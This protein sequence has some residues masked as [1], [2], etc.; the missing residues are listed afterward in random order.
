MRKRLRL[1]DAFFGM[2][3]PLSDLFNMA[4][5]A[6]DCIE[7]KI[8]KSH[9]KLTGNPEYCWLSMD[10]WDPNVVCGLPPAEHGRDRTTCGLIVLI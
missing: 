2:E 5:L 3:S 6:V 8:G 4:R 10:Q 9:E 7:D 1:G